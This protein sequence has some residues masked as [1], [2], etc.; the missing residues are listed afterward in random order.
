MRREAG[1]KKQDFLPSLL[2]ASNPFLHFSSKIGF[3]AIHG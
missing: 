3:E 1:T 2:L